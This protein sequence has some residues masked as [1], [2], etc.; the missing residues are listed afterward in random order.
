MLREIFVQF[1]KDTLFAHSFP[2]YG[3]MVL[4]VTSQPYKTSEPAQFFGEGEALESTMRGDEWSIKILNCSQN[5][6]FARLF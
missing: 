5:F 6:T 3:T 1:F 2:V 4:P